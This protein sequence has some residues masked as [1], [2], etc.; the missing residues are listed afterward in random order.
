MDFLYLL[1][2]LRTIPLNIL[3]QFITYFG[4]DLILVSLICITYWCFNKEYGYKA[5]FSY[6][7][8]GVLIQSLKVTFR[9]KRP[10]L[11]DKRLHPVDSAVKAATGYSFPSGH[12]QGAT[13]IYSSLAFSLKKR[14]YI[15]ISGIIIILVG[16]SRM[17]LGVHSPKDVLTAFAI[18]LVLSILVDRFYNTISANTR[19]ERIFIISAIIICLCLIIYTFVLVKTG[20]TTSVLAKDSFVTLGGAIGYLAGFYL[21]KNYV[22]FSTSCKSIPL[23]ILKVILGMAGIIVIKALLPL[24]IGKGMIANTVRYSLIAFWLAYVYP[25][26]IKKVFN[27]NL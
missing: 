18:A 3:A 19:H 1:Q 5:C 22:R 8:S 21:E 27:K 23:H 7:L 17:Y 13:S 12:T 2:N 10:F 20:N 26:I 24:V 14:I 11:T 15:I 6:F 25:I 9:I 16:I 4:Q